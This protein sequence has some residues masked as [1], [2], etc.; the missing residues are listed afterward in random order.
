MATLNEALT[1]MRALLA[2]KLD[3]RNQ[4]AD[5]L[6]EL[7]SADEPDTAK[8][9]EARSAKDALDSELDVLQRDIAHAEAEVARDAAAERL[10]AELGKNEEKRSYDDVA[11]VTGEQRTYTQAKD[12]SGEARFFSDAWNAERGNR[13]AMERIERHGREVEVE[14][15]ISERALATGGIAGLTIP[16]YLVDLAAPV[17]RTGAPFANIMNRHQLPDEGMSLVVPRGTT[18]ASAAE[19]ATENSGVSN[20]DEVWANLTVPVCTVA[21]QQQVSR[22]T[23]ERGSQMDEIIFSDLVR[24]HAARKDFLVINGSGSSGQPLGLLNTSG[25]GA[26]TAFGAAPT[27][28]LFNLKVAGA[29][30][31]VNSAGSGIAANAL[32]M[33]PR[34]WGWLTGQS[35]STG[36]PVVSATDTGLLNALAKILEQG[37]SAAAD[38]LQGSQFIGTHSSGLPVLTDLNIPTNVGTESEDLVLAVDTNEAHLWED[39]DGMPRQLSFEQTAGNNLTTTL[40]VYSYIAATF[41]RYP[42]AF[43]KVGG[44]DT[45][46][47][48][49]GLVAPSF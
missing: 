18:G 42:G 28:A 8:I 30:A 9:A 31:A 34:R 35:D 37:N 15:E 24:A 7:R 16:Q 32:V 21:G 47:A 25:I 27:A 44:V 20:T 11:R 29:I 5:E 26:A 14:R 38:P 1:N 23:L 17:L 46:G 10:S 43:A 40:V 45:G 36:R 12:K 3:E 4:K 2:S 22:Q 41:G 6:R 33:H 39:G 48:T 49:F 19:Q 13:K